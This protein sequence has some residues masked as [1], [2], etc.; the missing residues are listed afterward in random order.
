[1]NRQFSMSKFINRE[2]LEAEKQKHYASMGFD[3]SALTANFDVSCTLTEFNDC[4]TLRVTCNNAY[5]DGLAM[6]ST[7]Q[8]IQP[9]FQL[10]KTSP[11]GQTYTVYKNELVSRQAG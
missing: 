3:T 8:M 2:Q 6:L 7:V 10:G 11:N 5:I 9:A 4:F 1:M